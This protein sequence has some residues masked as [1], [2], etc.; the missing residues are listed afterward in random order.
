MSALC[1]CGSE[2]WF[3][4]EKVLDMPGE[5]VPLVVRS[6]DL[7]ISHNTSDK[8]TLPAPQ[9]N[10]FWNG[11]FNQFNNLYS[12]L[13]WKPKK[14]NFK[15]I[16]YSTQTF[17]VQPSIPSVDKDRIFTMSSDGAIK[18][19]NMASGNELWSNTFFADEENRG[20]FDFIV[21]KFLGGGI[22][23]DGNIIYATAG[24][25]KVI[26]IDTTN[27]SIIWT[28][29]FSS[30]VRSIPIV[31]DE[32]VI[33]QSIDNK[34]YALNKDTG[35]S[36]WTYMSNFEDLSSLTVSTP[37]QAGNHIIAKFSNDEVVALDKST[38]EEIWSN[39][40]VSQQK[41]GL[42][43]RSNF[44]SNN[45]FHLGEN[46][47]VTSNSKGNIFKIDLQTGNTIWNK[48]VAAT[49]K[50][51]LASDFLFF[52]SNANDLVCLNMHDG[53][54]TWILSLSKLDEEG[55]M[56]TDLYISNPVLANNYIYVA[57][58]KGE[59][60]TVDALNGKQ[61][62]TTTITESAYLGPIFADEHMFI[63]SNQGV[64]DI[65]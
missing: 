58:N 25:S 34:I 45:S 59:L 6:K 44:N 17:L 63:I 7:F 31:I 30:P 35:A 62:E 1:S 57:N 55:K 38:G 37:L 60:I 9:V 13:S 5:R 39:G 26:A 53:S 47:L 42:I 20:F 24:I 18:A 32:L 19:Y 56:L 54:A 16:S 61:I 51:W 27:G 29:G 43:A 49:G 36:V 48:D 14:S 52:I 8:I 33:V 12:N 46:Y 23:K 50:S 2:S 15:S 10:S 3:G 40:L 21:D 11:A 4:K 64:L 28:A 22:K 41:F 65:F